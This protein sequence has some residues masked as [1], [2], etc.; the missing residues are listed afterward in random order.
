VRGQGSGGVN[1]GAWDGV[2]TQI[3]SSV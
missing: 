2:V 1:I 3:G